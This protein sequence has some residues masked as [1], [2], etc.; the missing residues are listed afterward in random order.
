M[1]AIGLFVK[2]GGPRRQWSSI[3]AKLAELIR[4]LNQSWFHTRQRARTPDFDR[5]DVK[6]RR[7]A[8]GVRLAV[9]WYHQM[10]REAQRI[11]R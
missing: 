8:R 3:D 10:Q 6:G 11:R 7:S 1:A 2:Q 9:Y 5:L 4:C